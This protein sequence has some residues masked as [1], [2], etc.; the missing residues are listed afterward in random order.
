VKDYGDVKLPPPQEVHEK[1][2]IVIDCIKNTAANT[3]D[4]AALHFEESLGSD[5]AQVQ[6]TEQRAFSTEGVGPPHVDNGEA[7]W[8]TYVMSTP[9]AAFLDERAQR[10]A[11]LRS[12]KQVVRLH[13]DD[14]GN[15]SHGFN[16]DNN[17]KDDFGDF[18]L[19]ELPLL[20]MEHGSFH[21]AAPVDE[22]TDGA[23]AFSACFPHAFVQG[24]A[25]GHPTRKLSAEQQNHML[26][27]FAGV[28]SMDQ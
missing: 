7:V 2:K 4:E 19:N 12:I 21:S 6:S 17:D 22:S 11:H 16:N 13:K 14:I 18:D 9:S 10:V 28:P 27:Q 3:S 24:D 26:H 5:A 23:D 20:V 1:M 8:C 15:S 25:C